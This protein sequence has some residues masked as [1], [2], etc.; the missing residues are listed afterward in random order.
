MALLLQKDLGG[1]MIFGIV[2]WFMTYEYLDRKLWLILGL[3]IVCAG[4]FLAYKVFGHVRVRV[5][6]WI[7][8]WSDINRGGYQIA[9]SLFAIVGGG[10]FGT[11]LYQGIPTYIPPAA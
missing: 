3:L 11:G 6:S 1:V 8:P 9:H 7:D 4:G 10:W 2:F 5:N